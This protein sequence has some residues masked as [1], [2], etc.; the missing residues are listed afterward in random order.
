ML[1]EDRLFANPKLEDA[2][3]KLLLLTLTLAAAFIATPAPK[4]DAAAA[5]CAWACGPCWVYCP[6]T[7]CSGPLPV[8]PCA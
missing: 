7:V 3:R 2:M 8:C 4:A 1:S 5:A 6:C